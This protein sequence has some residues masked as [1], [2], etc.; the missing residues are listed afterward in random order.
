M[1]SQPEL[2]PL[3]DELLGALNVTGVRRMRPPAGLARTAAAVAAGGRAAGVAAGRLVLPCRTPPLHPQLWA[4][5][6]RRAPR[7]LPR[8][9]RRP[10]GELSRCRALSHPSSWDHQ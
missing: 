10:W 7:L 9:C 4:Q 3:V 8:P 1:D 2:H 5:A 6:R